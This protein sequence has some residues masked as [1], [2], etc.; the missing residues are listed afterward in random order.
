MQYLIKNFIKKEGWASTNMKI[1]NRKSES[2]GFT[3]IE[4]LIVIIIIGILA[5]IAFVVYSGAKTKANQAK[6]QSTVAEAKNKITEYDADMGYFPK[7]QGTFTTWLTTDQGGHNKDLSTEFTTANGYNYTATGSG[8]ATCDNT[9][10]PCVNY[11]ITADHTVF[12]GK[13]DITESN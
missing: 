8:G 2:K 11:Q 3:L 10:T 12:K 6:A 7:D 1:R 13:T 4:L 9:S 5:A